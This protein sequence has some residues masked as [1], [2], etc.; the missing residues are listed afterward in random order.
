MLFAGYHYS[1]QIQFPEL[2]NLGNQDI[3]E[4]QNQHLGRDEAGFA[5]LNKGAVTEC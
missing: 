3:S 5:S 4:P 2:E 1:F